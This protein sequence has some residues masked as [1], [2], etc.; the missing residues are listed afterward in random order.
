M[1]LQTKTGCNSKDYF[2]KNKCILEL[3]VNNHPG[4]MLHICGLFARRAC[5]VEKIICFPIGSGKES[6][7]F[8]TLDTNQNLEQIT[9]QLMKLEDVSNVCRAESKKDLFARIEM[10]IIN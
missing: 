9:K 8:M 4:V 1:I 3:Q 6:K 5:N 7:I 10:L 2:K